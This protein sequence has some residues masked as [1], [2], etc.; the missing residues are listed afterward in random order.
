MK[1]TILII[2]LIALTIN[3]IEAQT[4]WFIQ[5]S[6][7][8]QNLYDCKASAVNNLYLGSDFG[9]VF[10]STNNGNNWSVYNFNDPLLNSSSIKYVRG[11]NND[12]WAIVGQNAAYGYKYGSLDS[13]MRISSGVQPHLEALTLL[14]GYFGFWK[15]LP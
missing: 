15:C 14:N 8:S 7:T 1:K 9:N 10:H 11:E 6:F 12:N 3:T 2:V 13:V 5:P 4:G